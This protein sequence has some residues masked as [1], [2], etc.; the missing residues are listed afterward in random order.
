MDAQKIMESLNK[1]LGSFLAVIPGLVGAI[2]LLLIGVIVAKIVSKIIKKILETIQ[3]DRL[4]E[5]LNEIDLVRNANVKIKISAILS[6]VVYYILIL[7]FAMAATDVLGMPVVAA[8][9][10]DIV[11]YIPKA[12]TALVVLIIGLL[13]AE[14]LKKILFSSLQS[15]AVPSAKII[16]NIF[17]YFIFINVLLI[18]LKQAGISTGFLEQN[19]TTIVAGVVGAFALGY[20]LASREIMSSFLASFTNKN[21]YKV[22]DVIGLEGV[23]GKIV[24]MDNISLTLQNDD[25]YRVSFPLS[26]LNASKVEIFSQVAE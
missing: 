13:V 2:V 1:V 19:L 18:A 25:G 21:K 16:A 23:K 15:L 8:L 6:T 5:K 14:A 9:M 24:A 20:G 11:N 26:K 12:V 4:G 7:I 10:S 3:I 17:F 22:G